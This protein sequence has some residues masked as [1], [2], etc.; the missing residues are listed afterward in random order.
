MPYS[1]MAPPEHESDVPRPPRARVGELR[2][3]IV[4]ALRVCEMELR[5]R[6]RSAQ[7]VPLGYIACPSDLSERYPRASYPGAGC[8]AQ[9][10]VGSSLPTAHWITVQDP[11][12]APWDTSQ[13]TTRRLLSTLIGSPENDSDVADKL[14]NCVGELRVRICVALRVCETETWGRCRSA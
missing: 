5:G 2:I 14:S 3:R 10:A 11:T 1:Q 4:A 8:L 12:S 6:C 13:E 9:C 7:G